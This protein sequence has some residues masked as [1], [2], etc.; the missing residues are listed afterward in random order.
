MQLV[1]MLPV[2]EITSC[3][4][5]AVVAEMHPINVEKRDEVEI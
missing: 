4:I 1:R 3:Q 2:A 5:A